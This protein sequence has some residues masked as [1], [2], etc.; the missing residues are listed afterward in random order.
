MCTMIAEKLAATGA[1]KGA[2]GWFP[3]D[4]AYV[5]YDHPFELALEHALNLDFVNE[6]AGLATRVSVELTRET[7]R[8][9]AQGILAALEA[10]EGVD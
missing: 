7:A 1:A 3:L 2:A 6:A 8:A 9:L 10:S 5:S 4:H